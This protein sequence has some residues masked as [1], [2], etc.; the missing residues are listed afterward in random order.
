MDFI[1]KKRIIAYILDIIVVTLSMWLLTLIL[2]PVIFFTNII[3][4]VSSAWTIIYMILVL[5][6]FAV[7]E[8][9]QGS[10]LGKDIVGLQV[11]ST[12][13]GK[14]PT[15][16][17][18]IIRNLSKLFWIP[19]LLDLVIGIALKQNT[20]ILDILSKTTVIEKY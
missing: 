17:Q 13:D 16:V 10:S 5:G 11:V 1:M 20:K 14:R 8:Q 19:V 12:Y 3:G 9:M 2:Y 7:L 15:V 18:S 4:Q 6:Y